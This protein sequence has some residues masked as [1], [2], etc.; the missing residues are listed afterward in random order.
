MILSVIYYTRIC[1]CPDNIAVIENKLKYGYTKAKY[2]VRNEVF[3]RKKNMQL[4]D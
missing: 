2:N 4:S 1:G 3:R